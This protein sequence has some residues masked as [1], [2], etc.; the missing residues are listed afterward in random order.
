MAVL[1]PLTSRSRLTYDLER[2]GAGARQRRKEKRKRPGK[3]LEALP[4]RTECSPSVRTLTKNQTTS[5]IRKGVPGK[6]PGH[7]FFLFTYN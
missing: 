7:L 6:I 1:G 4:F 5:L 3:V 2:L